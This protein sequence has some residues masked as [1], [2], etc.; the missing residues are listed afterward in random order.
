M[1]RIT[2]ILSALSLSAV[3]IMPGAAFANSD[4]VK[5][6]D[7]S[8]VEVAMTSSG[9]VLVRGAKVTAVSG[10]TLSAS[11]V[12]SA[13]NL[14]W[15]V[16]TAAATTFSNK[17]GAVV[18][19][20]DIA[21]GDTVSFVGHFNAGNSLSVNA[22][23]VKD[24]T[25]GVE[26]KVVSGVVSSVNLAALSFGLQTNAH[27]AL[28]VQTTTGTTITLKGNA[29]TLASLATGDGIKVTGTLSA[30]GSTLTAT[31][32]E[33]MKKENVEEKRM[34]SLAKRWFSNGLFF[35]FHFGK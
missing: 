12:W 24:W 7:G 15:S 20:S 18:S 25:K 21:V 3:L 14:S 9:D 4:H 29:S 35:G 1:N 11:T 22:S 27:N 13:T 23:A 10:N 26:V 30:D 31:K 33:I 19:L 17:A 16:T 32:L 5:P 28:S 6:I 34:E 8:A 2:T